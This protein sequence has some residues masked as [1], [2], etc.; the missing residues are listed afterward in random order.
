MK[1]I[2][3]LSE[4][5]IELGVLHFAKSDISTPCLWRSGV[6]NQV[7]TSAQAQRGDLWPGRKQRPQDHQAP[8]PGAGSL[9]GPFR[10][11][12]A[13]DG[14]PQAAPCRCWVP[15][16]VLQVGQ[17]L[18]SGL[19]GWAQEG[20]E[21]ERRAKPR[22]WEALGGPGLCV[23]VSRLRRVTPWSLEIS[24]FHA[25]RTFAGHGNLPPPSKARLCPALPR[26]LLAFPGP[27]TPGRT[28]TP[29]SRLLT[30]QPSPGPYGALL[31]PWPRAWALGLPHRHAYTHTGVHTHT[32]VYTRSGSPSPPIPPGP[33]IR[34][35]PGP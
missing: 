32:C 13:A 2:H 15:R 10:E 34:L 19:R 4:I 33:D 20:W 27:P 31:S 17:G 21:G 12:S 29:L 8:A 24:Q 23:R 5:G 22:P 9:G 28:V 16:P 25:I 30:W 6:E 7:W 35:I 1:I 11:G 26:V 14:P 18:L 3:C